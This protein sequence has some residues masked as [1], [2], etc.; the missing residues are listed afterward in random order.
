MFAKHRVEAL[1]DGIFAIAMTLLILDI[2]VPLGG[3]GPLGAALRKDVASWISFAVSFMLAGVFWMHQ[4][5][6]F[7]IAAKWSKA[8]LVLTFLFLAFVC[9]LPFSTSLW[10]HHLKDPL[11]M[12]IYYA[13]QF[14]LALLLLIQVLII[15]A[16]KHATEGAPLA[17]VRALLIGL[18]LGFGTAAVITR[19]GGIQNS[20]FAAVVIIG[21]TRIIK[22]RLKSK[23]QTA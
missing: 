20:G 1:S 11:A 10:G 6:V 15:S 18:T 23:P 9:T 14:A 19:Y 13:N 21:A 12:S 7:E 5:R 3:E 8:N 4:H 2:K 16:R 17:D 22:K